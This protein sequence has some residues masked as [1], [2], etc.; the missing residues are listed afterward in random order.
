MAA[1]ER[2]TNRFGHTQFSHRRVDQR[3]VLQCHP[4]TPPA[5]PVSGYDPCAGGRYVQTAVL[6]SAVQPP[7]RTIELPVISDEASEA[8]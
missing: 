1:M 8:R 7:S 5:W 3:L 4:L 6:Y 2:N